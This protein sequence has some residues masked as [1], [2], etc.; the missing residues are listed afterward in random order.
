[1]NCTCPSLLTCTRPKCGLVVADNV[2]HRHAEL[3]PLGLGE[4]EVG[5]RTVVRDVTEAH[6]RVWGVPLPRRRAL[7]AGLRDRCAS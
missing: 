4:L 1:V 2:I 6:G 7:A 3:V 5:G